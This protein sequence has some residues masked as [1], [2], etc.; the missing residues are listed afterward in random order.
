[1]LLDELKSLAACSTIHGLALFF[2]ESRYAHTLLEQC[3]KQKR[4]FAHAIGETD[5]AS[6][7]QCNLFPFLCAIQLVK[8]V[9]DFQSILQL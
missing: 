2:G 8:V 3:H 9:V 5:A 6:A 4:I 1:V 7:A